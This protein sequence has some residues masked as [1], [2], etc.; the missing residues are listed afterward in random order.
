VIREIGCQGM[1]AE[2]DRGECRAMVSQ[3]MEVENSIL[4]G[5]E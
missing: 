2:V 1:Q 3:S 4:E 5:V